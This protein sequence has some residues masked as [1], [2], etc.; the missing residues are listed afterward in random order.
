LQAR[1][2]DRHDQAAADGELIEQRVRQLG[3]AGGDHDAVVGRVLDPPEGAVAAADVDV[4]IAERLQ[5]L[6]RAVG[7]HRVALDRVDLAGDLGE[8]GGGVA[9]AGA[10]LEHPVSGSVQ[11]SCHRGDRRD[12]R[13]DVAVCALD[14]S[15]RTRCAPGRRAAGGDARLPAPV[16]ARGMRARA[17]GAYARRRCAMK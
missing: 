17:C 4:A 11:P 2:A 5:L 13:V 14:A 7:E 10:D 6:A 9:G 3:P 8:D 15:A 16:P 1:R 12:G